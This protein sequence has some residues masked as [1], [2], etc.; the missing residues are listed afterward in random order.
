VRS[1]DSWLLLHGAAQLPILDVR[2]FVTAANS[3]HVSHVDADGG[4]NSIEK[5]APREFLHSV[6]ICES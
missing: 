5:A 1:A 4:T 6:E 3:V 2:A